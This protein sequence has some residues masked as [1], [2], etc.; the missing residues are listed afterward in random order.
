MSSFVKIKLRKMYHFYD[1]TGIDFYV[2]KFLRF[3][4]VTATSF[5][6]VSSMKYALNMSDIKFM[7]E[8]SLN[9]RCILRVLLCYHGNQLESKWS[10]SFKRDEIKKTEEMWKYL[11]SVRHTPMNFSLETYNAIH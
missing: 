9:K 5:L 3:V 1:L 4:F 8:C 11:R 7:K 6:N 2:R 10:H